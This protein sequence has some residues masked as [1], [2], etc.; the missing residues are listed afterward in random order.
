MTAYLHQK[1]KKSNCLAFDWY[2]I[3][4]AGEGGGGE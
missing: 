2:A 3:R 4:E 1:E